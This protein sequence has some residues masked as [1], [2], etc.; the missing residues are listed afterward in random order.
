M[1]ANDIISGLE[2]I[3]SQLD[4]KGPN[5]KVAGHIVLKRENAVTLFKGVLALI[6][7]LRL[8][9]LPTPPK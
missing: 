9:D 7:L 5:G 6:D 1:G 4:W 8:I 3:K 2:E